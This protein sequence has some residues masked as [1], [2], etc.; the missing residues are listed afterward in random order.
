MKLKSYIFLFSCLLFLCSCSDSDTA[1][2]GTEAG[3]AIEVAIVEGAAQKGPFIEGST[4]EICEL[5]GPS[6]KQTGRIIKS[7][8][9][10]NGV[11]SVKDVSLASQYA[12]LEGEGFFENEVTGEKSQSQITLRAVVDLSERSSV[13]INLLTH[14]EYDRLNYLVKNDSMDFIDAKRKAEHEI[15]ETFFDVQDTLEF[16]DLDIFGKTEGDAMLLAISVLVLE[17]GSDAEF[18]ERMAK[19]SADIEKDGSFDNEQMRADMADYAFI[20]GDVG[21]VRKNVEKWGKGS[22]PDF[23]EYVYGFWVKEYGLGECGSKN[24]GEIKPNGNKYSGYRTSNFLCKD[25]VW[26][27]YFFNP[28]YKYGSFTDP[29]DGYTYRT[30]KIAGKTWFAENLRY[31]SDGTSRREGRYCFDGSEALCER[32]GF[33]LPYADVSCPEGWRLPSHDDWTELFK[34]AG[35]R[36]GAPSKLRARGAWNVNDF[37]KLIDDT[38]EFGF[39]AIPAGVNVFG[40]IGNV[41]FFFESNLV[42]DEDGKELERV[43]DAYINVVEADE[44]SLAL[45]TEISVRCIQD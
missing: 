30:T 20:L 29:R 8:I 17:D 43:Y 26:T 27:Q 11:F 36:Y 34:L 31:A 12:L 7:K 23:E 24:D 32:F 2:G 37:P 35:G 22:A 19:F 6:L 5:S 10:D 41:A 44:S 25:G 42:M 15:L 9:D 33:W 28:N 13:N 4:L 21:R 16:E 45:T 1:G 40:D 14:L 18:S 39:S 3:N 38:D